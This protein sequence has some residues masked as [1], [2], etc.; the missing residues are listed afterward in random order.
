MRLH[1]KVAEFRHRK[2]LTQ[3]ELANKIHMKKGGYGKLERGERQ[4]KI[5]RLRQ[6]ATALEME[7]KDI[8]EGDEKTVLNAS[9]CHI[10][11][12][13]YVNSTKDQEVEKLRFVI[14][15]QQRENELLREQVSQLKEMVE[16]MRK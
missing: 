11:Q 15:Q 1:E 16:L 14:E 13:N 4:L 3:Q 9:F 10:S 8:L 12:N 2:G 6:I 5:P 7:L